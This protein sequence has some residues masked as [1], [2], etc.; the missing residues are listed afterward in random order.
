MFLE[1]LAK[2]K[3]ENSILIGKTL[4]TFKLT[5]KSLYLDRKIFQ[6]LNVHGSNQWFISKM[7][8]FN[9]HN[10]FIIKKNLKTTVSH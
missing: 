6:K 2:R 9:V 8:S 7:L 5:L 4:M 1:D 3:I 10:I